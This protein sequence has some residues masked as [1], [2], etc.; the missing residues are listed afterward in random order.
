MAYQCT[1]PCS[2]NTGFTPPVVC[3]VMQ[4]GLFIA[5]LWGIFLFKELK[6]GREQLTY[7][8]G[9]VVLIIG[10]TMLALSK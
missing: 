6:L 2:D 9:G 5:G 3:V 4:A 7:W 8:I 10:A 1:F